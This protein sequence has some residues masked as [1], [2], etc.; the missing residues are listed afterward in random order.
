[1]AGPRPPTRACLALRFALGLALVLAAPAAPGETPP[2]PAPVDIALL[3]D[4]AGPDRDNVVTVGICSGALIASDLVLT[5][6]HCWSG[7]HR[8]ERPD[9]AEPHLCPRLPDQA[10]VQGAA[11]E[12]S[13]RWYP[14]RN[15][16]TIRVGLSSDAPDMTLQAVAYS[17][18]RCAD[19][20]LLRLAQ[21]VPDTLARP[22]PI[23]T[24]PPFA[25]R[26]PNRD[27]LRHASFAAQPNDPAPAALRH[28]GPVAFWGANACVLVGLPPLRADGR[29]L[30]GGDS[31]APLLMRTDSGEE[32]VAGIL[33]VIGQPDPPA[34][35]PILPA[36]REQH[37]SWTPTWR[38][39]VPVT[40][41]TDIGAWLRRMAPE[42]DHR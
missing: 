13:A 40:E 34:C 25:G 28:T 8:A 2:R 3:P 5:A 20:A 19:L 39:P 27:A 11:W 33:F 17:L 4:R 42:A 30:T 15:G 23:L 7:G 36:P 29:R 35:G 37:G 31:G 41:A 24:A 18:P 21:P 14:A 16:G 26:L 38:P 9:G 1:M 12:D 6:G 22:L 32:I 10:R